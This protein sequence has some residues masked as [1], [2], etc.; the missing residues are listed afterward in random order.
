M[1]CLLLRSAEANDRGSS[2]SIALESITA[3]ALHEH[4]YFLAD[5]R[6]E[7]REAGTRGGRASGD[8]LADQFARCHLEPAG[9]GGGYHQPFPFRCR[10]V[11]AQLRGSDPKLQYEIIL[12]GA[13]YDHVGYGSPRN[14]RGRPGQIHNG[15]DDNASGTSGVLELAQAFSLLAEPPKRTILFVGWDAEEKGMLGSKHWVAHPTVPLDNVVLAVNMDMIGRLRNDTVLVLGTRSG[16]GLRRFL[17]ERNPGFELDFDWNTG[18]NADHWPLFDRGIPY[19]TFH[20]GR[21]A[22]YHTQNDDAELINEEGMRRLVQFL[23]ATVYDLANAPTAPSFRAAA[24]HETNWMRGRLSEPN[25]RPAARLGIHWREPS[26]PEEGVVLTSVQT[27]SPAAA[28]R[29]QPGDRLVQFAGQEI[30]SSDELRRAVFHASGPTEVVVRRP[31][32]RQ[33]R[34]VTAELPR[35]QL[36]V[37]VTWRVDPAA[38]STV[39]LSGVVP[40]SPADRAGLRAGD[41][42]YQVAGEDFADEEDFAARLR[43]L[44][45]PI[46]L[47]IERQG[48]LET[49]VVRLDAIALDRAA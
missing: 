36:R 33:P 37:G 6:Q 23:F 31:S 43:Q 21:H 39:V 25:S 47:V 17:A 49:V 22:Q 45:G 34:T 42:V 32:E 14:S 7:G 30:R 4:V 35:Q 18:P 48:R 5:D 16:F 29:L 44:P 1:A 19:L 8:Y 13:H 24:R 3:E 38:P 9:D 41:R 2:Y 10:N 46:E 11:L 26:R 15:A 20:T 40:G 12:V 27:G 28:A